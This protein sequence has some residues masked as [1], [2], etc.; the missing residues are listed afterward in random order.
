VPLARPVRAAT[1]FPSDDGV[2]HVYLVGAGVLSPVKREVS[3]G[4]DSL[5]PCSQR[6]R[7]TC[8]KLS[9]DGALIESQRKGRFLSNVTLSM[10]S[11]EIYETAGIRTSSHAGR[12]TFARRLNAKSVGARTI[13]KLMRHRH[14]G[15]T[16]LYCDVAGDTLRNAVELV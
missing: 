16:A 7:R 4:C 10:L 14:I 6:N 5:D 2:S 8:E 11:K 12:R 13:Q 15:T 3:R 9:S 1:I